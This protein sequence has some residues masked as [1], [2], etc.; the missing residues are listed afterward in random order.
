MT[1]ATNQTQE[2]VS[3]TLDDLAMFVQIIQACS[4]RGAFRPEE[5]SAVG[6]LYERVTKFLDQ[7]KPP[8]DAPA[9]AAQPS[10]EG[11]INA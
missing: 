2:P 7:V 6:A 11:S 5:M 1:E 10:V 8:Q 3:L 9:S 4:S